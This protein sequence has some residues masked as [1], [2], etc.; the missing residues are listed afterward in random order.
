MFGR[1]L[2]RFGLSVLCSWL[3]SSGWCATI[4]SW[5][6]RGAGKSCFAR[7]ARKHLRVTVAGGALELVGDRM[8]RNGVRPMAP[9][10]AHRARLRYARWLPKARVTLEVEPWSADTCE[11]VIRPDRRLPPVPDTYLRTAVAIVQAIAAEVDRTGDLGT[12]AVTPT[13]APLRRAS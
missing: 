13:D 11:L 7:L 4:T 6:G 8:P 2:L 10:P 12:G 9:Q 5:E 3:S 1:V